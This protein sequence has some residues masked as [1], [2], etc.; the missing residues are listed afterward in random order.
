MTQPPEIPLPV[1][2]VIVSRGRPKSLIWC[3]TGIDGLGYPGFEVVVVACPAGCQ[4]VQAAGYETRVKLIAY[5]EAN[6]SAA[7]NLGIAAAAG[8][9]WLLYRRLKG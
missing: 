1:S 7:R 2:I 4:A 8:G 3:L 5:D 6:I 9:A